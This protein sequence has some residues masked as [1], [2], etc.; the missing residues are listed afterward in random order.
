MIFDFDRK[1]TIQNELYLIIN[2][3]KTNTGHY[4]SYRT[5]KIEDEETGEIEKCTIELEEEL[6]LYFKENLL[7]IGSALVTLSTDRKYMT[8]SISY[9]DGT[10]LSLFMDNLPLAIDEI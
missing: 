1:D 4:H 10:R 5:Y 6:D 2:K 3:Y 9:H 7:L 8:T